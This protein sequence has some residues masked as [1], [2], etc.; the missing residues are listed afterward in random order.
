MT[1]PELHRYVDREVAAALRKE[2]RRVAKAIRAMQPI[3]GVVTIGEVLAAVR[4][5][6]G[7]K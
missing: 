6:K 7:R 3:V 1:N 5:K 4:A 2:R